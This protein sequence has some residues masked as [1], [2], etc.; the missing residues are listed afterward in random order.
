MDKVIIVRFGELWLKGGN[1]YIFV[2]KLKT[3][4]ERKLKTTNSRIVAKR[5]RFMI[6]APARETATVKKALAYVFGISWYGEAYVVKSELKHILKGVVSASKKANLSGKNVRIEAH[7]SFKG[8]GFTSSDIVSALLKVKDSLPFTPDSSSE[9]IIMVNPDKH[10]TYIYTEKIKGLGGMPYGSSGRAVVLISGGI[11]SPV[12]AFYAM[13]RGLEVVYLHIHP[14]KDYKNALNSKM[15]PLLTE[16][17]RYSDVAK[18]Y[19]LPSYI[20]ESKILG[21]DPKNE[22][23]LFKSFM[24]GLA[25]MLADKEECDAIVTGESLAQVSSQTLTNLGISSSKTSR[26]VI[27][28]LIC[29]DKEEI[30]G[31]AKR[32]MTYDTSILEYRDVCAFHSKNPATAASRKAI[33]KT[34][35]LKGLDE[36]AASTLKKGKTIFFGALTENTV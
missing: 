32:I 4:I 35:A 13:K 21:T 23:V 20:F 33:D 18:I 26:L 19:L 12:A 29:F 10:E 1:R 27:R 31:I 28:P 11:D 6:Y 25:D 5:D 30:V 36:A 15:G 22:M 9:N 14:F 34:Y 2:R 3:S 24:M 8:L 17:S 7:R 16:L